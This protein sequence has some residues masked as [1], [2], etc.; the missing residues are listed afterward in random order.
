SI[1]AFW[2]VY[3]FTRPLG[4]SFGDLLSQP[5]N[6]GGLGFGTIATSLIF[7]GVIIAVVMWMSMTGKD[8]EMISTQ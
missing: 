7:L 6:Y 5:V 3:I 1:L 8:Q 2:L 4:A